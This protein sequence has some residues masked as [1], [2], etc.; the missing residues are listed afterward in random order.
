MRLQLLSDL[1][2]EFHSN[3]VGFVDSIEIAP[4]ID[5]LVLAGDIVLPNRQSESQVKSVFECLA[6]K[7]HHLIFTIGNHE[8]YYG[9]PNSTWD[10]V[11]G[12]LPDNCRFLYNDELTIEK[13]HFFGGTM[14]FPDDPMGFL[15]RRYLNDFNKIDEFI[16]W[17]FEQNRAFTLLG[18][19]FIRPETIVISHHLPHPQSVGSQYKNS[20]LNRFFV[21][22]QTDLIEQTKPRLW[23]HGH[24]HTPFD[25][26][27]GNTRVVCNP[28]GYP[29]ENPGPYPL[30]VIE[31]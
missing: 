10:K 6:A 15:Y 26:T 7:A 18:H 9:T 22:D 24:T 17:V 8:Y 27:V 5:F 21:S 11:S 14:W 12:I 31:V 20:Q 16:P 28:L 1:H 4:D 3:P 25:Y 30:V 29:G 2:S 23:V 13:T 19:S